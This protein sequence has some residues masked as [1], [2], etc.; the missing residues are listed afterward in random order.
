MNYLATH[1]IPDL[2]NRFKGLI[3]RKKSLW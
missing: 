1:F 3:R 2:F